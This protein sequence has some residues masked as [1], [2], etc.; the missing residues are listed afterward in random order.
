MEVDVCILTMFGRVGMGAG[1]YQK[2]E[3]LTWFIT[4]GNTLLCLLHPLIILRMTNRTQNH[5]F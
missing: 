3:D 5:L 2:L 4:H 1:Q